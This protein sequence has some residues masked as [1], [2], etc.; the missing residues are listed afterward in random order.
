LQGVYQQTGEKKKPEISPEIVE[1]DKLGE[2]R[3]EG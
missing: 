3:K 1:F 2:N